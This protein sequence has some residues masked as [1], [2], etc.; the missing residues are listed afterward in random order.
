MVVWW[1]MCWRGRGVIG[2]CIHLRQA[3]SATPTALHGRICL[4]LPLALL[5]PPFSLSQERQLSLCSQPWP[6]E[7]RWRRVRYVQRKGGGCVMACWICV[8]Q[9][10]FL[11]F[12]LASDCFAGSLPNAR[13]SCSELSLVYRP[14]HTHCQTPALIFV[15]SCARLQS[16]PGEGS[17]IGLRRGENESKTS[18]PPPSRRRLLRSG[19][20]PP[21]LR[22]RLCTAQRH[23]DVHHQVST[24]GPRLARAVL[25]AGFVLDMW[26]CPF[27]NTSSH[28]QPYLSGW[29][30][31]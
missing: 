29:V 28:G 31:I 11:C 12:L 17:G 4:C 2:A 3:A 16:K 5:P 9:F 13:P 20:L 1:C 10:L 30:A 21:C 18:P 22:C 19:W 23:G 26:G 24:C 14:M 25:P 6:R 8:P 7:S 27:C 15:Q